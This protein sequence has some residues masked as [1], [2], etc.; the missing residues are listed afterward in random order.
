MAYIIAFLGDNLCIDYAI[1]HLYPV[2]EDE[3]ELPPEKTIYP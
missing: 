3:N 1:A 2:D